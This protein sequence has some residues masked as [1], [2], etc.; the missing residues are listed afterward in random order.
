[1]GHDRMIRLAAGRDAPAIAAIYAP[2]VARTAISFEI[3]PPSAEEMVRR[4]ATSLPAYPWLVGEEGGSV[5]G[6]AYAGPHRARPAYRW[7]VDVTIYVADG[8]RRHG[9]GRAL[10][11]ALLEILRCQGYHAAF[12]GIT[13]PNAGSVGLHEAMGFAPVGIFRAAGFKLGTWHDVGWWQRQ[14]GPAP[15]HPADPRPLDAIADLG[16]IARES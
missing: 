13:L 7:S 2:I 4:I 12:A 5:Q 15:A 6:Y 1:M 8:A 9:V 10:Y 11:G 14:L 16:E 3:D